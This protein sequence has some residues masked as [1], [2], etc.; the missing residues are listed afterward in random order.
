MYPRVVIDI[1]KLHNNIRKTNELLS[2]NNISMMFVTKCFSADENIIKPI[3]DIDFEYLADSRIENLKSM[4]YTDKKKVLLRLPM[5][6]EIHEVVKY[7]DLSLVSEIETITALNL[8]AS[9]QDKIYEVI[10]MIELGDLREGILEK[11]I[12]YYIS[13]IL[14]L[15]SIKLKG[16]GVNL[17]CYGSVIPDEENL[18]ELVRIKKDIEK[19]HNI[20]IDMI[21]GGN[22]SSVHLL[23]E[24]RLPKEINNLRIGEVNL[25]ARESAYLKKLDGLYDDIFILEAQIIEL[26]EKPTLPYGNIGYNAFGEKISYKDEGI[27]MRAILAVGKQDVDFENM[28]PID[29]RVRIFGTSSDHLIVDLTDTEYKLG[30]ILSFKLNYVS[31][32]NAFTSKY[33]EKI[34]I[35]E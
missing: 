15:S 24:N 20:I 34:Y 11:D 17:T 10:L 21:S 5:L 4:D 26:K 29:E 14:K 6:S 9:E 33:I 13:E 22:S 1:N 23:M 28:T 12:D 3:L 18:G 27:K 30:D 8:A 16:I 32:L 7:T 2:S 19:K 31:T 25:F 35:N